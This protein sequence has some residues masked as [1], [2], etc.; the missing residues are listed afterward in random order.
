MSEA[1][2]V[3]V[4]SNE[5]ITPIKVFAK[6]AA[7]GYMGK[8]EKIGMAGGG[9]GATDQANDQ[10]PTT[11]ER[12]NTLNEGTAKPEN[13]VAAMVDEASKALMEEGA[14]H[15]TDEGTMMAGET[16]LADD[17]VREFETNFTEE[18]NKIATEGMSTEQGIVDDAVK[19][20]QN[21]QALVQGQAGVDEAKVE[22]EVAEEV[23]KIVNTPLAQGTQM[24]R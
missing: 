24:A 8:L 5:E 7:R 16:R 2:G 19:S 3:K 18:V 17:L 21:E 4:A 1:A 20:T 11:S 15:T 22:E 14:T 23:D 12:Q 6:A 9:A 10:A 13:T